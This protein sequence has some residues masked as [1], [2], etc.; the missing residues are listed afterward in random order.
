MSHS[1]TVTEDIVNWIILPFLGII[2][3]NA[4]AVHLE[5]VHLKGCHL[6]CSAAHFECENNDI[7]KL[8]SDSQMLAQYSNIMLSGMATTLKASIQ[9]KGQDVSN[10]T[11]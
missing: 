1:S 3:L 6:F 10:L 7:F 5:A 11:C 8:E 4:G 2:I 9:V